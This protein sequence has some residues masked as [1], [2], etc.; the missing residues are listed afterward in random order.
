MFN[1]KPL[2]ASDKM[3][4]FEFIKIN[5]VVDQPKT[6]G[7]VVVFVEAKLKV[8]VQSVKHCANFALTLC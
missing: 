4:R 7:L 3:R 2:S 5:S 1:Q 8:V 6:R